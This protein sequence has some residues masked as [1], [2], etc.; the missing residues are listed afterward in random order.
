MGL[1]IHAFQPFRD[2]PTVSLSCTATIARTT[3]SSVGNLQSC[4]VMLYN[5]G[6]S[7]V[8]IEIGDATTTATLSGSFIIAAGLNVILDS[9]GNANYMSGICRSGESTTLYA[10][11]GRG[12]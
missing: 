12:N 2:N 6:P 8:F 5:A 10:S 4:E 9:P 1:T 11:R 3:L 7:D